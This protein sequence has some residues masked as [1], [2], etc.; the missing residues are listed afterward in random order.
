MQN[1]F[2]DRYTRREQQHAIVDVDRIVESLRE[3]VRDKRNQTPIENFI[4]Q[5]DRTTKRVRHRL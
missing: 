4:R 3:W 5:H 2:H 1:L